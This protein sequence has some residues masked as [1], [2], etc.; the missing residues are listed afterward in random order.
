MLEVYMEEWVNL[1]IRI[2]GM[3]LMP[4]QNLRGMTCIGVGRCLGDFP[5]NTEERK[6]LGDY[7]HG[8]TENGAKMLLRDDILRCYEVLKKQIKGFENLSVWRQF[9]LLYFCWR[10][11]RKNIK[12]FFLMLRYVEEGNFAMATYEFWQTPYAKQRCRCAQKIARALKEGVWEE[13][14]ENN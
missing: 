8:I 6:A 13:V 4:Y 9:A 11:G 1:I 12:K 3:H 10:L 14:R 5:L 2:E 7:M